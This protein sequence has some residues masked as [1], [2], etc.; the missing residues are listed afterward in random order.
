[1][2]RKIVL[3][4]HT[5]ISDKKPSPSNIMTGELAINYAA[6]GETLYIKNSKEEIAEFKDDKY[7][8]KQLSEKVD[9]TLPLTYSELVSLRDNSQLIPGQQYRITDYQ[10]TTSQSGTQSAGHVFD[11]IVRADSEN[12]LNEEAF[13][14]QHE[15][16]EYFANSDLNAW[17]IWYC[18]DNDTTQFK[19]A[20]K[21]NGKGVIYRMIDEFDNDCPYD[22]KNIQFYRQWNE[23]KQLW[24]T[25]SNG[26]VG[27]PCYT[28]SSKGDSSATEFTDTTLMLDRQVY[29]NTIKACALSNQVLNN[30]CFFGDGC[31][32]NTF[33]NDCNYNTFGSSCLGNTFESSCSYNTFGSSCLGNTF[34]SSCS[35]NTFGNDCNHNTFGSSCWNNTFGND[36]NYNS[37]VSNCN[38]NTFGSS[39]WNNTFGSNCDSNTFYGNCLKNSF[40]ISCQGNSFGSSCRNNT[41]YGNCWNNTFESS[42]LGNTVGSSCD[43]NFFGENCNYNTFGSNCKGNS[44]GISCQGNS[45][46]NN[47]QNNSFG[48]NC[49]YNTFGNVC[50]YIKFASDKS[51]STKYNYYRNNHFGDGC[52]YIV[53]TG[54]ETASDSAQVQN[55]NFAQGLQGTDSVYLTINGARNRNFE[56]KVEKNSNGNLKIFCLADLIK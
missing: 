23:A 21:T 54:A 10:C 14:I 35:Y 50:Y 7:Y 56:T 52:Q 18:L 1:M 25:T 46:G 3:H 13:A 49:N 55:Y 17:Q 4:L 31:Y 39:C 6:N 41:F 32:G 11:I 24:S 42:C 29:G 27:V 9:K 19:W 47:C 5:N 43:D 44:L 8:Q 53:F 33:G 40:G 38:Y 15:G 16:D 20:D 30:N 22:F 37:F 48:E 2:G 36:C 45:L 28:F 34:E 51:A 12:K 26:A